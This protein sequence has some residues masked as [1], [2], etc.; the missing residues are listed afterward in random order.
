MLGG[1][2]M[3]TLQSPCGVHP[4]HLPVLFLKLRS[5]I[6][7]FFQ[8]IMARPAGGPKPPQGK[9]DFDEDD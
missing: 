2:S 4:A 1:A 8:I 5:F 3:A 9:K 7:F 6:V